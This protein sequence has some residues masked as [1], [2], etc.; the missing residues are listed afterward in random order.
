MAGTT[1]L[2][3]F[4]IS[5]N[6]IVFMEIEYTDEKIVFNKTLSDLDRFVRDFVNIL[7]KNK[8]R[9]VIISGYIPILFGRSRQTE[10]VDMFIEKINFEIFK[11]LWVDLQVCFECINTSN[12]NEAYEDYLGSG[13]A[14]RFSL[15]GLFV[16]NIEVKYPSMNADFWSLNNRRKVLVNSEELYISPIEMQISFKLYLGSEK[17]IEDA[18]Y[19]Y[20]IFKNYIDIDVLKEF[21]KRFNKQNLI[22]RHLR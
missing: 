16:P 22:T 19:L 15:K 6:N 20:S 13:I 1:G 4:Y 8:V 14:I 5:I 3:K 17:D 10:D 11:K 18:K 12:P 2:D 9:Y 21:S 7:D